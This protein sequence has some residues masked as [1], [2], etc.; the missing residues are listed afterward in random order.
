MTNKKD[1]RMIMRT[2]L[3]I[4]Q[5]LKN[6]KLRAEIDLLKQEYKSVDKWL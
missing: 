6:E 5:K 3:I 4:E 2:A 1:Y